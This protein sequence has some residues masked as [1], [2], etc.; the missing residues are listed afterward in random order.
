M[1]IWWWDGWL[2]IWWIDSQVVKHPISWE[3]YIPWSSIKWKM[4]ASLEM[5]K[6]EYSKKK[7]KNEN[8]EFYWPSENP[9]EITAKAFGMA[10]KDIKIASRILVSDFILTKEYKD[11]YKEL[12][13]VDFFEDK[14]ENT[15]PRFLKWNANPRHIERVPAGVEFE[16]EIILTPVEWWEYDISEKELNDIL[17]EWIKYLQEFWLWGWVSRWN[18]RIKI[19]KI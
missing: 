6:W 15:I 4:R 8:K 1:H 17:E 2:K 10:W 11:K 7:L 5:I 3:P 13:R 14:S 18:G 9:E 16:G 19:E 12:W